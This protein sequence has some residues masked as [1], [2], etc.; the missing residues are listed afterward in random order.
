MRRRRERVRSSRKDVHVTTLWSLFA[1][2][3]ALGERN[4]WR[5]GSSPAPSLVP[6]GEV[7]VVLCRPGK[8]P[9]ARI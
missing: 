9:P 6:L 7:A 5:G 4:W 8:A 3:D 1:T 2:S